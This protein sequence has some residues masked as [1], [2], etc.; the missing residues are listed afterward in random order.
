MA[1]I[2]DLPLRVLF[3]NFF[4]NIFRISPLELLLSRFTQ[5]RG[6][7]NVFVKCIPQNYQYPPSSFRVV[8]RDGI[9]Y[10]LDLSEY[11]EWV[12]FWGLI[13]E[14][15]SALYPLIKEGNHILDVGTNIGETLLNFSKLTGSVGTVIGFEP[16]K[17]NY[18]KCVENISLNKFKNVTVFPVALS[19]RDETLYFQHAENYNSGGIYMQK[20]GNTNTD[21]VSA[22]ML[23]HFVEEHKLNKVDFIKIDVEGFEVNVV[24]GGLM[25]I[26][27]F[28]PV[29]FVEVDES[30]LK[31]QGS[32]AME[33]ESLILSCGYKITRATVTNIEDAHLHY[34]I[35]AIP[36]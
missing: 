17:R 25:T 4:R 3:L 6:Y 24:K 8:V 11:M 29:L 5:K 18:N 33:L 23:D 14:D 28:R 20:S 31:R 35:I 1:K 19:D 2:P 22:I 32:S 26:K 15:R 36:E 13:V 7:N 34:D 16:V 27:K 12:I 21:E 10:R 9:K 30:N